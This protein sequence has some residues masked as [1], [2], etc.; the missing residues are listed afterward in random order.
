MADYPDFPQLIGTEFQGDGGEQVSVATSGKPRIRIYYS[1]TWRTAKVVHE[2]V[3]EDWDELRAFYE[4]VRGQP[5]TWKFAGDDQEYNV[6]FA[7]FPK[8]VAR[9]GRFYDVD[10]TLVEV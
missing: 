7:E 10:C 9:T 4:S 5:F 3:Q 8:A 1:Q 6:M 2:L